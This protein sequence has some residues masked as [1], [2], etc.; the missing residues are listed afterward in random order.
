MRLHVPDSKVGCS[1]VL[2]ALCR[3]V[4][5]AVRAPPCTLHQ[6]LCD[7]G[8]SASDI[9]TILF[10]VVRN[11]AGMNEYLKLEYVKVG[12]AGPDPGAPV[13]R[14][15][16]AWLATPRAANRLLPHARGGRR[17][18]AAAA[19]WPAGGPLQADDA[20]SGVSS[21]GCAAWGVLATIPRPRLLPPPAPAQ[22][23]TADTSAAHQRLAFCWIAIAAAACFVV[24][25]KHSV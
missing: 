25:A 15:L 4:T 19:L 10:R 18:L 21:S 16:T 11:F 1:C 13:T 5:R 14:R 17:Q 9:I 6:A 3:C 23:A 20:S 12:H 7:M 8:Y 2:L 24:G 22:Q